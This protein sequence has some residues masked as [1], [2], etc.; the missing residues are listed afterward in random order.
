MEENQNNTNE[1]VAPKDNQEQLAR[2]Q[3]WRPKEEYN[4]DPAKWVSAET[5]LAKGELID[6]IESLGKK[7]KD[8][9]KAIQM[10]T[11]HNQ[12]LKEVEFKK[13]VEYLK[14]QKK[15]AYEAG[16]VDKI[17]EIDDRLAEVKQKQKEVS[18]TLES[19]QN[20]QPEIDPAFTRWVNENPWYSSDSE[21]KSDA[22]A[23]GNAYAANNPDKSPEDVLKYV[24]TKIKKIYKD[25]FENPNRNKVGAVEG[26]GRRQEA[27]NDSIELTENE[28]RAMNTFV[29]QGVMTREEYIKQIKQLRG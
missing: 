16:D 19:K 7:L 12:K 2:E 5:F 21:M 11:E 20:I 27:D 3:G 13:A 14:N 6:R 26:G 9:E 1:N 29:R 28:R 15:Q 4:G 24:T 10:L 17:I 18:N 22:D 23:F 8:S 25:K